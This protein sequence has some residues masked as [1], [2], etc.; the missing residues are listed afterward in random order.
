MR[1]DNATMV[2]SMTCARWHRVGRWILPAVFLLSAACHDTKSIQRPGA[3]GPLPDLGAP[4]AAVDAPSPDGAPVDQKVVDASLLDAPLMDQQVQDVPDSGPPPVPTGLCNK[5]GFC[6]M[7]PLPQG[8][9]LHGVWG[10]ALGEV[11]AVGSQG[12]LLRDDGKG[13]LLEDPGVTEKTELYG[14]WAD[15]SSNA[16]A[17]G[18]DGTLIRRTNGKW[19]AQTPLTTSDLRGI[20]GM[21]GS[22]MV[23]V[24]DA[25]SIFHNTGGGLTKV[26]VTPKVSVSLSGVWGSSCQDIHVVGLGGTAVH[27]DGT[28]W[29]D[30]TPAGVTGNLEA[31]WGTG[32][33]EAYAVGAKGTVLKWNSKAW[34]KVSDPVLAKVTVDLWAVGGRGA[35]DIWIGGA[36]GLM[37]GHGTKGW[38]KMTAPI[39]PGGVGS[40]A[41]YA[42]WGAPKGDL[43][44]VGAYG[45]MHVHDGTKWRARSVAAT[46]EDLYGVWGA[47]A[48]DLFVV[49]NK[50]TALRSSVSGWTRMKSG[51]ALDLRAVSGT[52]GK[53]VF[54]GGGGYA[55]PS[56][57]KMEPVVTY[58]NGK[59][60]TKITLPK[61]SCGQKG[62]MVY[63]LHVSSTGNVYAAGGGTWCAI[64]FHY[65]GVSWGMKTKSSANSYAAY[66]GLWGISPSKVML[67]YKHAGFVFDGASMT[68]LPSAKFTV[69]DLWGHSLASV[70]AVGIETG[71]YGNISLYDGKGWTKQFKAAVS[72]SSVWGY[73]AS[74]VYTAGRLGYLYHYKGS[75]WDLVPTGVRKDLNRMWG[76]NTKQLILV[77]DD[78]TI[79]RKK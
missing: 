13:W 78:G 50:G 28:T 49:G 71:H 70:F 67:Y 44:A 11:Y 5:Q 66:L 55:T 14:V 57:G 25:G 46:V 53:N 73:S 24:G 63:R 38:Y 3:D 56:T 9:D 16:F 35:G 68:Q 59:T 77:G 58:F 42:I 15:A 45:A 20:W 30:V 72:L 40:H 51:T 37:L 4:D 29:K 74:D 34:A 32:A 7:N 22:C 17:V 21:S 62:H 18:S 60:W 41:I 27:Y 75:K 69:L 19:I 26:T 1:G 39:F 31:V 64:L 52:S 54:A 79:L 36:G 76:A 10:N 6:W 23:V 47:T 65:L 61:A 12:T 33:A 43:H 8:Q 2:E 48:G